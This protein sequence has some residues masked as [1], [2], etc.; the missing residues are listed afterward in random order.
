[1]KP[2]GVLVAL[3]GAALCLLL[4]QNPVAAQ[5]RKETGKASAKEPY[6]GIAIEALPPALRSQLPGVLPRDQGILVARVAKDSPAQKAGLQPNDILLTFGDQK[7]ASPEQLVKDVRADKPGQEVK[8]GYLRGGKAS[9]CTVTLGEHEAAAMPEGARRFRLVPDERL[10]KM[11]EEFQSKDNGTGWES[12]DAMKLVRTEGKK[13]HTEIDYRN[14]DGKK[15]HKVFDGTREEIRKAIEAEKDLPDNE[16]THL[17]R[18][19]NLHEPAF[20]FHFPPLGPGG[21][22]FGHRL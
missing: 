20:E 7:V 14:K 11:F 1:M 10:R 6:L 2:S 8:I 21:P 4:A 13:W 12:F 9:T 16:R 15:E 19:L 18:A 22:G 5:D 3:A 17:L